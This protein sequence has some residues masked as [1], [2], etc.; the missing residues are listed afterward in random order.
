MER[1]IARTYGLALDNIIGKAI[2]DGETVTILFNG[3]VRQHTFY[4]LTD[5]EHNGTFIFAN[6]WEPVDLSEQEQHELSITSHN[7]LLEDGWEGYVKQCTL[8]GQCCGLN[9]LVESPLLAVFYSVN[10][11]D[12]LKE[13]L[14]TLMSNLMEGDD[15]AKALCSLMESAEEIYRKGGDHDEIVDCM[16]FGNLA[17]QFKKHCVEQSCCGRCC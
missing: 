13:A 9:M 11:D 1:I 10:N 3:C 6:K 15:I 8:H 16:A 14:E 17:D 5:Y 4:T 7:A 2:V 12:V